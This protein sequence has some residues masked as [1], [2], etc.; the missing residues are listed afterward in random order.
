[1]MVTKRD[2]QPEPVS[3]DKITNRVSVL[4]TGLSIDPITVAQKAIPGL[5]NEITS[6]ENPEFFQLPSTTTS[7]RVFRTESIMALG[8]KGFNVLK[9]TISTEYSVLLD[10]SMLFWTIAPH[11]TIVISDPSCTIFAFPNSNK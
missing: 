5:F 1:M 2:G 9:S 8:L 7:L 4:S 10:A 3:L 6:A 11:V